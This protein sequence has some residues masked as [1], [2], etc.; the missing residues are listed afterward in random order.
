MCWGVSGHMTT[1]RSLNLVL[2]YGDIPFNNTRERNCSSPSV[3]VS[4]RLLSHTPLQT[5]P[6]WGEG[7]HEYMYTFQKA[8]SHISMC[9]V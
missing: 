1:P 4:C 3:A 7:E 6:N 5:H 9:L 8:L 2:I